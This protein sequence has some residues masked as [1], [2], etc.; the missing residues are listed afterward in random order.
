MR[1]HRLPWA[2]M[3]CIILAVA[4]G[5]FAWSNRELRPELAVLTP[6]PGAL[7]REALSFGDGQFFYRTSVLNLQTVGDEGGRV[8]RLSDYN[9]DY[10]LGWLEALAAL[11][12]LSHHYIMLAVRYF[13]FTPDLTSVRR[14]VD[15]VVADASADPQRK[16]YWLTQAMVMAD[17]TLAD[18]DYTLQ[19]AEQL[20]AYDFPGLPSWLLLFPAVVLEKM[21]RFEEALALLNRVRVDEAARLTQYDQNWVDE[22]SARLKSSK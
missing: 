8:T 11:D 15:F 17:H 3:L 1:V 5:I 9:Y 21:D 19:I 16:W 7:A 13:G 20:A 2:G 6:P 12:P 10:V 18:L 14:L 22:V 4:H